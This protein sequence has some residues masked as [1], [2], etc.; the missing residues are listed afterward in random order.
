VPAPLARGRA[1]RAALIAALIAT[2]AAHH[3]AVTGA[4][5]GGLV[6]A[7]LLG[8][9]GV[10]GTGEAGLVAAA[11]VAARGRLDI[12]IVLALALAAAMAGGVAGWAVGLRG[13]RRLVLLPGPLLETRRR[14][15]EAGERVYARHPLFAVYVAPS[16]IAGIEGM[17]PGRF[18]L[19]NLGAAAVWTTLVGLG[20]YLV[21]R[22]ILDAL[23]DLGLVGLVVLAGLVAAAVL[24]GRARRRP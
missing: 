7:V 18:V 12:A 19:A 14:L 10:P 5:Y 17:P 24:A 4:S 20:G 8:W 21:G 2:T 13:G 9:L 23:S 6:L 16:V 1:G 15:L 22:P 11:V 3:R